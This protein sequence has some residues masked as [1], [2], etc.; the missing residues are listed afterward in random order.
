[1]SYR[2]STRATGPANRAGGFPALGVFFAD[3]ETEK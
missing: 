1:M 3:N 2:D